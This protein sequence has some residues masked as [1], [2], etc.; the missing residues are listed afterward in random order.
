MINYANY[1]SR[2]N[3]SKFQTSDFMIYSAKTA[4]YCNSYHPL[5]IGGFMRNEGEYDDS[6]LYDR[7]EENTLDT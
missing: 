2:V 3:A 4:F 6:K 5:N 7:V 1:K